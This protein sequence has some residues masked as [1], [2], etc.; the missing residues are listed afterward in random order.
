[1]GMVFLFQSIAGLFQHPFH[2]GIPQ[3][4]V[5]PRVHICLLPVSPMEIIGLVPGKSIGVLVDDLVHPVAGHAIEERVFESPV[6]GRSIG[7][8]SQRPVPAHFPGQFFQFWQQVIVVVE[9]G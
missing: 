9:Q 3:D 1:M 2:H 7:I 4:I 8:C 6:D 5:H